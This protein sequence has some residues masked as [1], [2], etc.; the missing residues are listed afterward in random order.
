[1]ASVRW[2]RQA[3]N[4]GGSTGY[5]PRHAACWRQERIETRPL[6]VDTHGHLAPMVSFTLL[7][8][9]AVLVLP[10]CGGGSKST[11]APVTGPL[12]NHVP[13]FAYVVNSGDSTVSL[14]TVNTA[15]GQLRHNG[16]VTTGT[17]PFSIT[18]DP[19]GKFAYVANAN[20]NTVS[21]YTLNVSTG[22]L[23]AMAGSPFVAGAYPNSVTVDPSGQ[24]AYVANFNS[25][26]SPFFYPSPLEPPV[27]STIAPRVRSLSHR[28][29]RFRSQRSAK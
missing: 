27:Q 8:M 13:R 14:Y 20:S 28:C 21:A 2:E 9:G 29:V 24:F 7:M 1:M 3:L 26:Q 19:S 25:R 12:P 4:V 22:A 16:Y 6:A 11:P 23:V 18:V 17:Y 5:S 10:G 15:T